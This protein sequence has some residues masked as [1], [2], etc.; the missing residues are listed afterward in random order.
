[1]KNWLNKSKKIIGILQNYEA[2]AIE[3]K[4]KIIPKEPLFFLKPTTS[5]LFNEKNENKPILI[6]KDCI[7]HHEG[8]I[9]K[10]LKKKKKVELGVIIS[11]RGKKIPLEEAMNYV[12][13][14]CLFLDMTARNVQTEAKEKGL[15][16]D[17]AKGFDTF[18]PISEFIPNEKIKNPHHLRLWLKINDKMIQNGN[19]SDMIHSIPKLI[20]SLSQVMTLEEG[21]FIATGT[22]EGVGPIHVGDVITAGIEDFVES[23]VKFEV[24]NDE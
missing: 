6:P 14:Y 19:T 21:D 7:V 24:E 11:K 18:A 13:G 5:F 17:K 15:P 2:H 20:H 3:M 23:N 12:A 9:Q 8:K 4:S 22:P 1:M 16:W 10:K